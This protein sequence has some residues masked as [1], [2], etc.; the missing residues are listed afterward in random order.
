[1]RRLAD[2]GLGVILISHNLNDVFAGGRRHRRALPRA[3]WSPRSS[4]PGRHLQPGGRADH[5]RPVRRHGL[6]AEA[7]AHD[8]EDRDRRRRTR[9]RQSTVTD[10][11]PDP[12]PPTGA[13]PLSGV[14]DSVR[15][16]VAKVRGGDVGAL[17]AVLGLIV[18]VIVFSILR[19]ER[20]PTPSTSPTCS[21]RAP[22][23]VVFAMGLVFVL[24]LGEIDLSAGYT[25]G[26]AGGRH[27]AW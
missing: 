5:H 12:A 10:A 22:P 16:Y 15:D 25:G 7:A 27:R 11:E 20:S 19:P 23:I 1:M 17:P 2:H 4:A 24:L 6:S 8:E 26:I 21:S 3:R 9:P 13:P 18:L 14:G